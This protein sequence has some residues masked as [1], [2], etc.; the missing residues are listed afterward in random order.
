[1]TTELT[2]IRHETTGGILSIYRGTPH[3][4]LVY[5]PTEDHADFVAEPSAPYCDTTPDASFAT[6]QQAVAYL[7]AI[8]LEDGT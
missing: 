5:C 2:I 1:M 6:E 8:F 3:L 4:G 7:A